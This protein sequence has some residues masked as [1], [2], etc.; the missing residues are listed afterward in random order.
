M[1]VESPLWV[2]NKDVI[3]EI[4]NHEIFRKWPMLKKGQFLLSANQAHDFLFNQV[5]RLKE[6][7]QVDMDD[8]INVKESSKNIKPQFMVDLE[9]EPNR[10]VLTPKVGYGSQEVPLLKEIKDD[11]MFFPKA[12]SEGGEYIKRDV[13]VEGKA[14]TMITQSSP[15]L[16]DKRPYSLQL[17]YNKNP[18]FCFNLLLDVMDT[19]PTQ[20]Q[21]NGLEKLTDKRI[22]TRDWSLFFEIKL[23][24]DDRIVV[25][26]R[27]KTGGH[28]LSM[29]D[30]FK[31]R[32]KLRKIIS[33][34]TG[35]TKMPK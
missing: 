2:R 33:L 7:I 15:S 28:M 18:E 9:L 24:D 4:E 21:W 16:K 29:F 30:L 31:N 32:D 27:F 8:S 3:F 10:I 5:P 12:G 13:D 19:M 6:D 1:I 26:P 20:W 23:S 14:K 17:I 22:F 35:A 34:E 25:F 11:F